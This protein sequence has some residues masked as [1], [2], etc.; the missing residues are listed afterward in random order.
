MIFAVVTQ[1]LALGSFIPLLRATPP[2]R[3]CVA[4]EPD[5]AEV[6]PAVGSPDDQHGQAP[7]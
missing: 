3:A 6:E 5:R 7:R 2:A 1:A 4:G